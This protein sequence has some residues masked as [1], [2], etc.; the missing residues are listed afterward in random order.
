MLLPNVTG[1]NK[2]FSVS[3]FLLQETSFFQPLFQIKL[4]MI[5]EGDLRHF[6]LKGLSPERRIIA[7][8]Q[9]GF[10]V[11]QIEFKYWE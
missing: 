5:A 11:I 3:P 8:H 2:E 7:L 4:A 6:G 9:H 10:T 1:S